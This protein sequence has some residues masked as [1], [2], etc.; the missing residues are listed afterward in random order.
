MGTPQGLV[1]PAHVFS[2]T[3]C[4]RCQ[5]IV[6]QGVSSGYQPNSLLP[7]LVV[8]IQLRNLEA[9]SSRVL[10]HF[11]TRVKVEEEQDVMSFRV[12]FL[13]TFS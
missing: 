10:T 5:F 11:P 9:V 8:A 3:I 12:V 13:G 7:G 6:I 2:Q 4:S 1:T